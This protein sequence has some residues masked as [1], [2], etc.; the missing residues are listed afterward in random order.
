M[1]NISK[2]NPQIIIL[3]PTQILAKDV[4]LEMIRLFLKTG[5]QDYFSSLYKKYAGK[6]YGK[7]LSLLKQEDLAHDAMQDIFMKILLNLSNFEEKSTFSTWIYSIT[8]NYCIDMIRRKKKEKALFSDDIEHTPDA[9]QEEL[10]DE[11][12]MEMDVKYLRVVLE[13][14][15][16]D[17]KMILLMKYQDDMSI[18]DV[19]ETL[20]KTESAVKMRLKRAKHKAFEIYKEI[21]VTN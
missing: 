13:R 7:C 5:R 6:V 1:D 16:V 10:S 3:E 15:P 14:L 2:Q 20:R 9:P 18:K 17:D 12:I 19:A 8:Y 4:D 11:S 21:A